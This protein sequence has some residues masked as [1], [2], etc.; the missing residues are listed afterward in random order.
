MGKQVSL[1]EKTFTFLKESE[2]CYLK[3]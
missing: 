3:W 1:K 2:V